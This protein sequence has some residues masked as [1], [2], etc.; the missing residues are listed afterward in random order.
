MSIA[1]HLLAAVLGVGIATGVYLAG[2]FLVASKAVAVEDLDIRLSKQQ[3]MTCG[4]ERLRAL[5]HVRRIENSTGGLLVTSN[6]VPPSQ[7]HVMPVSA[8]R[9]R[10]TEAW[11]ADEDSPE[12]RIQARKNLDAL[13]DA[14]IGCSN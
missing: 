6:A 13:A 1:S 7:Q 3:L 10:L 2:D 8:D 12:R 5:P 14:L 11:G 9:V 4:V